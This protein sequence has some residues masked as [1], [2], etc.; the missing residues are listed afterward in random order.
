[1]LIEIAA[2]VD[3]DKDILGKMEFKPLISP[4]LK[5]MDPRLFREGLMG[6]KDD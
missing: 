4:D 3:L 5:T 6:L 1:M 2:G